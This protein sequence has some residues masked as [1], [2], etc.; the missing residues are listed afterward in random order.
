MRNTNHRKH[1]LNLFIIGLAL[2]GTACTHIPTTNSHINQTQHDSTPTYLD[3]KTVFSDVKELDYIPLATVSQIG[4]GDVLDVQ[5][6]KAPEFSRQE[7]VNLSGYITLPLIGDI[8]AKDLTIDQLEQR[9]TD[10]LQEKYLQNP[11]VTIVARAR[12]SQHITLD[13]SFRSPGTHQLRD[14]PMDTIQA[15]ALGG[16]LDDMADTDKIVLFRKNGSDVKAYHLNITA[17]KQG[18][19]KAPYVKG[20]DIIIAHRS[21]SRYWLREVASSMGSISSIFSAITSY[22]TIVK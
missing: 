19:A 12:G 18:R 11:K 2:F 1:E 8:P 15:M 10:K 9:I 7:T 16:G 4:T 6:F 13:G 14:T 3:P 5:V 21:D 22:N 17:I 20:N